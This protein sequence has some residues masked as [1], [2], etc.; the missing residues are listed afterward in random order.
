M[1]LGGVILCG[2][3]ST[4]MGRSKASLPFGNSTMLEWVT[5]RLSSTVSEI[6]VVAAANQDL[7]P[8]ARASQIVRDE[9]SGRGPLE[10]LRVGLSALQARCQIAFV[11]SCDAP[12]LVPAAVNFL[13]SQ[14]G[15]A[16]AIVPIQDGQIHPLTAIY[17][18]N[19]ATLA[20]Q[21]LE[22]GELRLTTFV[23]ACRA[24]LLYAELLRSVDPN[25]D[26]LKNL[27]TPEE[28]LAA[29]RAD[30]N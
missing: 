27:N 21:L 15:T 23:K 28:Y 8:L 6:V 7:P 17:R 24:T 4:R 11:T 30:I 9:R 22:Q 14:L 10:G 16:D 29:K 19:L 26:S 1:R 20:A 13:A 18:T 25:L 5:E 3:L 12:L 2:G